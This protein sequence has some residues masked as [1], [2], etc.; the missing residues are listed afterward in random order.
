MEYVLVLVLMVFLICMDVFMD[1]FFDSFM[2]MDFLENVGL[3][4]LMFSI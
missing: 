3:L 2:L 1:E 4:L